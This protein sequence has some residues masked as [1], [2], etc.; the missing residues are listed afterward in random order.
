[1]DDVKEKCAE[2]IITWLTPENAL[3]IRELCRQLECRT[4]VDECNRFIQK[5]FIHVS[6]SKSFLTIPLKDI[7]EILAMDEI[8]VDT[9]EVVFEAAMRWA[10]EE[11]KR[12]QYTPKYVPGRKEMVAAE[13]TV[14]SCRLL[15]CVRLSLLKLPFLV[16][17]VSKH[18]LIINDLRCRDL[19]DEAKNCYLPLDGY[20][21]PQK[22]HPRLCT[23][24]PGLIC[25]IGGYTSENKPQ[26][27]F[28]IYN[29]MTKQWTTAAFMRY[30]RACLGLAMQY[31][32]IY[33]TCGIGSDSRGLECYDF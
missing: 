29:P 3:D 2:C 19:V 14:T 10:G 12:E 31:P 16:D 28:Q 8:F 26:N 17:A 25:I 23:H 13:E 6:R 24:M 32:K 18:R 20:K 15:A 9:E 33:V 21:F 30:T 7:L 4:A 11:T 22:Q 5:N 27:T 1:M